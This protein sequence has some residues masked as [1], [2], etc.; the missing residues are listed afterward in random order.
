MA[1]SRKAPS[2]GECSLS[3]KRREASLDLKGD[4]EEKNKAHGGR[5][6]SPR[7]S[8]KS[9][10]GTPVPCWKLHENRS[11]D[12]FARGS[13]KNNVSKVNSPSNGNSGMRRNRS[14]ADAC[15]VV[16]ARKLAASVWA[17]QQPQDSRRKSAS[18]SISSTIHRLKKQDC[19]GPQYFEPLDAYAES[20]YLYKL[21]LMR[22]TNHG[23]LRKKNGLIPLST[24]VLSNKSYHE[25]DPVKQATVISNPELEKATKWDS[26]VRKTSEDVFRAY[27]QIKNLENQ[28]TTSVSLVLALQ[29]DLAKTRLQVQ[30]L[31][32]AEKSSRKEVDCFLKKIAEERAIWQNKEQ[33]RIRTMIQK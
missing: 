13:G 22:S 30:E 16:S 26:G 24:A 5:F 12:A 4:R 9:G 28:Q 25:I 21:A 33:E 31:E 1:K 20:S 15:F 8:R 10:P 2:A 3:L 17:L 11:Y 23:A 14:D 27:H 29:N 6:R 7:L 32:H 19:S 18:A